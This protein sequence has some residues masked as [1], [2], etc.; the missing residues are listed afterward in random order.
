MKQ[1]EMENRDIVERITNIKDKISK[2]NSFVTIPEV[3]RR[4]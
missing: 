3:W 4:R 1:G 2:I